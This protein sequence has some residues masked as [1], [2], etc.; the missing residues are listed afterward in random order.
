MGEKIPEKAQPA[1]RHGGNL[2]QA[3]LL[4][5]QAPEPWIDLST[6][7]N[8]HSYPHSP[9]PASAFARLP[10]P[11]AVET[12]KEIAATAFGASSAAHIAASPGTQM[13]MPLLAQT[14]VQRGARTCGV[15]SPAYA[16]HAR[17][18][19]IAGL[20]ITEVSDI[21]ALAAF[22]HAVIINPNNPDGRA[23]KRPELL[24]L[25]DAMRQKGGMLVVD[26]AFI[27]TGYAESVADVATSDSLVVLRSFGKFYGMAGIRLGFAIGHPDIAER[28]ESWLG[29]WAISGPALHIATE[30]L[31]D[32]VWRDEI[33]LRLRAESERLNDLLGAADL[34][35]VG[36]TSLFTLIRDDRA[37]TV[38]THLM[39]NGILTRSFDERSTELRFGLPGEEAEWT[40]LEAAL[41][42]V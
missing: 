39:E 5:P 4:F 24:T 11:R 15:L 27:E 23:W 31:V 37:P 29:P 20:T 22:D 41:S 38:C 42:N 10:E 21:E 18:A 2:G 6:G 35:I 14:A 34:S 32:Q 40:R 36:G 33:R 13:L 30:A 12:L 17:T 25:A 7:I 19:R 3:R 9:V 1:I 16:E 28:L 8:P 26:E